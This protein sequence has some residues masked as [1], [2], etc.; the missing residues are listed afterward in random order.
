MFEILR[1]CLQRILE[2]EGGKKFLRGKWVKEIE[3]VQPRAFRFLR[4]KR[5]Q[6]FS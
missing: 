6:N 5:V 4:Q 3:V 2:E 1:G